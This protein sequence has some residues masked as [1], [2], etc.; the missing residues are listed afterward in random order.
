MVKGGRQR[1][2]KSRVEH[3][4]GIERQSRK[5]LHLSWLKPSDQLGPVVVLPDQ[6]CITGAFPKIGIRQNSPPKNAT[7][8]SMQ[9]Q[10]RTPHLWKLLKGIARRTPLDVSIDAAATF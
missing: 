6:Q 10:K 3:G 5:D 4:L 8:L 9:T 1:L 7:L 2:N